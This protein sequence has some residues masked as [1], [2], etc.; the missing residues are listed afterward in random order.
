MSFRE[1]TMVDVKEILRRWQAQQSERRISRE[2]GA[3]RKTVGRYTEA[4]ETVGLQ[5]TQELNDEVIAA[6]GSLVQM[7]E[8]L[9]PGKAFELLAVHKEKVGGWLSG[10]PPLRLTKVHTLLERD[11][12]VVPYSTLRRY[13]MKE[14]GWRKP[15]G[16][17]LLDDPPMGQEAQVDFGLMGKMVDETTG[18]KRNLWALLVTLSASRYTFVWLSWLQTTEAVCEGL[19]AAW[20]FFGGMPRTLVPDNMSSVVFK[21]DALAPVLVDA[22]ADYAQVR[23][24]FV[25]PARAAHPKDKAKVENQVRYVRDNWFAGEHFVDLQHAM[26]SA[27]HWCTDVAGTRVH[28]TTRKVPREV[29]ETLEKP[30]MLPPPTEPFDVPLWVAAKV[31]PDHHVQ[32]A[33]G[34]YSVPT[35]YLQQWVRVRADKK[36]V[37]I[38]SGLELVKMHARVKKGER[39]TDVDDYPVGK[40]KYALRTVDA[41][42]ARARALGLHTGRYAERI[43]EGPLPWARMR[44]AYALLGLCDKFGVARVEAVCQSALGFD[45]VDVKRITGMLKKA[46]VPGKPSDGENKVIQLPLPAPRF[47]R[48]VEHFTTQV[49]KP[50]K[51]GDQ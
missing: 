28:G 38:Y 11:G 42:L 21:A 35:L 34:L 46:M 9:P 14:L 27:R 39:S 4:A 32:V 45:V 16:T 18:K 37:K 25:D 19:D 13:V 8:T 31:H 43:L 47:A 5:A 1:L 15:E 49:A 30:A 48:P 3:D 2:T 44:Q 26:D 10:K 20:A 36:T 40:A 29:F 41:V 33:G 17:I 51:G 24:L 12:V 50:K 6:V 7:R 22:F 23:G